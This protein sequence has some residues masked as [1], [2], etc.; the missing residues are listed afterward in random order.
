MVGDVEALLIRRML[1][2]RLLIKTMLIR[3]IS[4]RVGSAGLLPITSASIEGHTQRVLDE[5]SQGSVQRA[6]ER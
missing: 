4:I 5:T 1:I 6:G 2:K 3:P